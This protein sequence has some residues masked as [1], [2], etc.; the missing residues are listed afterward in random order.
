M[1]ARKPA[2]VTSLSFNNLRVKRLLGSDKFATWGHVDDLATIALPRD[3]VDA[4]RVS[5]WNRVREVWREEDDFREAVLRYA[6]RSDQLDAVSADLWPEVVYP[7]IER[8]HWQRTFRPK[9]EAIW[10]YL[11]GKLLHVIAAG[12]RLDKMMLVAIPQ[13]V[14]EQLDLD[15]VTFVDDP[16]IDEEGPIS[17]ESLATVQRPPFYVGATIPR[18]ERRTD[19][20]DPPYVRES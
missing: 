8:A 9:H 16:Q 20:T 14:A 12:V 15:L 18:D 13:E 4:H 10:D 17:T 6:T 11:V 7:L 19:R 3:T 2:S 5:L 1:T